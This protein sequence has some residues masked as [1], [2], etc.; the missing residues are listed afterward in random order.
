MSIGCAPA[1]WRVCF[2]YEAGKRTQPNRKEKIM[3]FFAH[4]NYFDFGPACK[5]AHQAWLEETTGSI[6]FEA[7]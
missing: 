6:E 1:I 3:Q 5:A 4:T 7:S 2:R